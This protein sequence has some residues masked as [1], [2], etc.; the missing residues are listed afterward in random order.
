MQHMNARGMA[1]LKFYEQGPGGGVALHAYRDASSVWTIGW[2]CTQG[3]SAGMCITPLGADRMLSDALA[4]REVA[5]D[6]L[7]AGVPTTDD[8]FSAMLLLLYN[9]GAGNFATSTVLRQHRALHHADAAQAFSLFDEETINGKR[10]VEKGLVKR[11][12]DE[13]RLYLSKA[14]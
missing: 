14:A 7:V 3:V 6:K 12:A 9:I 13:A 4:S 11:R 1:I 10:V 5:L 8:Q 2:G